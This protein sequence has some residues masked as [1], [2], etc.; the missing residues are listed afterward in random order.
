[1]IAGLDGGEVEGGALASLSTTAAFG[2]LVVGWRWV[3]VGRRMRGGSEGLM[4]GA[5]EELVWS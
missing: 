1:M 2:G 5:N 4:W 3:V